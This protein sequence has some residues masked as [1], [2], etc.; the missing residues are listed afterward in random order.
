MAKDDYWFCKPA[1]PN[2][3]DGIKA[4]AVHLNCREQERKSASN[5]EEVSNPAIIYSK[6]LLYVEGG[7]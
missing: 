4:G 2:I 6:K 7:E 3:R 1:N 5:S